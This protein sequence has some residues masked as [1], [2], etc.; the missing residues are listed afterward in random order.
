MAKIVITV[1]RDPNKGTKIEV[2][3]HAG[4]GCQKL[5]EGIEKALGKTVK[6]EL[7][8][9]FLQAPQQQDQREYQ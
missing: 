6:D 7:T 9:E 8:D 3:G 5:T 1:P 4:P 2:G